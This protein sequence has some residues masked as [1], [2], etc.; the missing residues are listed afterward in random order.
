MAAT[1]QATEHSGVQQLLSC[2]S[3]SIAPDMSV[4]VH[5]GARDASDGPENPIS[6]N[7]INKEAIK[8]IINEL[9]AG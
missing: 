2:C 8:R 1:A 4:I 5:S 6:A 9:D 3:L 7:T